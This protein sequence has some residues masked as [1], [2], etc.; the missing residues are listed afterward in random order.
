MDDFLVDRD[1]TTWSVPTGFPS[2]LTPA[3][4]FVQDAPSGLEVTL[5]RASGK[6][7]AAELR[8]G[9]TKRRDGRA[10][11]V[12]LVAFYPTAEGQRVSLCGPVGEPPVVHHELEVSQAERLAEV[13]LSEP[14]H[15]AATRFLLA[16]MPELE[17]PFPG[18]RNIGL[19]ATQ[20]LRAG[21][22]DRTDWPTASQKSLPLLG[23]R[24]RRLV[25]GL[26]FHI[27][28]LATNASMLTIDGR[29]HAVAVFCDEDE[30]FEAP[31]NR[32]DN[33]SPVSRALALA[34][35]HRVDWVILTRSSEIRLYAA[36]PDTGVGRKGRAETFVELNLSL[37]PKEFAGYLHLL[38]SADALA[39]E[40]TLDQILE[41]SADFVAELAVRLRERVYH[42]TVPALA[43]AVAA[44][45]SRDRHGDDLGESDLADAYEQVMVILFRL[46]FVAYAEDKDLLPYRTNGRYADHSLSHIARLLA[47]DR[48]LGRADYDEQATDLWDDVNQLW[49]AV[50]QGN[51]DWGVPAYNG[52]LF[53]ADPEV[54]PSG[55]AI[56]HISLTNAEFGPALSAVL[57]DQS[58][59]GVGP[60]D[61]RSL[62]VR[63]FGTIYE[64]LLESKLSVAQDDLAIKTIK[65]KEQYVPAA[66]DDEVVVE[67]GAVYFH[68]RSGVRKATGSY[69]TKPFAV[70][71]LLDN[72]LEPALDDHIA[73]LDELLGRGDDAAVAEAF[74]D[75]RCA[76][77][78]MGSAHFLVAAVDRIEARLSAWLTLHPVAA[79]TAELNRLRTTALEALGDLADGVPIESGS[80]L[81]RQVARHC[82]Y[83]V[84]KNQVAVELARL[85]IWV[86]TFVP[87]LP[88]SFLDHNLIQ[89]DSLTGVGI[90]D[91]VVATF[92]PDADPRAPSL[93]RNQIED[94]LAASKAA[95]RRLARTSDATKREIDEARSAHLEAQE[96]LAGPRSVFDVITAHR[97]G[98]CS[99]PEKFEVHS[100]IRIK[101]QPAV[102]R[103]ITNLQPVHFPAAFPEVFL[104]SRSG[105]DCILG[106]PPWEEVK[107]E[108]LDF[109]R[110]HYPGLKAMSQTKQRVEIARLER[111]RPDLV[112]EFLIEDA[113]SEQFR[114]LL[115]QGPYPEMGVGEPDLYKAFCW[116]FW[117][118]VAIGG[119]IGVVL[120][121]SAFAALGSAQW[122]RTILLGSTSHLT[123]CKN[124]DEWLFSDVNPGFGVSMASFI[125][126]RSE[127]QDGI[128]SVSGVY[129]S[130]TQYVQG[131]SRPPTDVPLNLLLRTDSNLCIPAVQDSREL[132]LFL[133]LIS[134][135]AFGATNREDFSV[136][137]HTEFHATSDRDRFF[138]GD[139][140]DYP[141]Y[142]HRNIGHYCFDTTD[143]PFNYAKYD[144]A[145]LELS[146]RRSQNYRKSSSPFSEMSELWASDPATL[147]TLNP[148]LA[149]R[150]VIHASNP[151]KIWFALIPEETI[152]TNSAPY[153]LVSR[154]TLESQ[155]YLLGIMSSCVTDWIGHLKINLNLNYFILNSI[156]VPE[157]DSGDQK[158]LRI[159]ELAAGLA[160]RP[161]AQYGAWT[162][163]SNPITIEHDR[164]NAKTEI[165]AL[166]SIIFGIEDQQ[167]PFLFDM[168]GQPIA[169]TFYSFRD[170]WL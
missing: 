100:F 53:S 41:H 76:D 8:E 98:I 141:V 112:D 164:D 22:P 17:S 124:K 114:K 147:P 104:R 10:S 96:A 166:A 125:C 115:H 158:C 61:F 86:H 169:E 75:F 72:A 34:D 24:G 105:F 84:D 70:E 48:R 121:R 63:E 152:L 150:A 77:I 59:E 153:L 42:Q 33:T 154:G 162:K 120:P 160:L 81:R 126:N 6:P 13:A 80:L 39:D 65:G 91:E 148:R 15:H 106:N 149:Y 156:P 36:R 85:A 94:L 43:K 11:P 35:Q 136:R 40:G 82:V 151:R 140:S 83:G 52:G 49:D 163:L 123:I 107:T 58:P 2:S 16:A 5:V 133:Q 74:F 118:L 20:E 9:W 14:S 79:V 21:V 67:A 116:R 130:P 103:Y 155:A 119:S 38:F 109:W 138:S 60:V 165:D 142:N 145:I 117:H 18:L 3:G 55:A 57:V 1:P 19:L 110:R 47:D 102:A 101:D 129:S 64:G 108:E 78:A 54:S 128:L 62:S 111:M 93:F 23:R 159:S 51:A 27:Q 131:S 88:L 87:G 139:P 29:N 95:L 46:L 170:K 127:N 143:G 71:H 26:G 31:S 44:R 92:E 12:L 90:L 146:R 132:E 66:V 97:A 30:P 25:E 56:A 135:P 161:D 45:L 137:P 37:V 73:R 69:F 113:W 32:F 168:S 167:V 157:F 50:N 134:Y 89:G 99:L 4:V 122:R 7:R 144:N 28:T 68:N